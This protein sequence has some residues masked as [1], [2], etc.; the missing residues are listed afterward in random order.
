M[1]A[2]NTGDAYDN[3]NNYIIYIDVK[4]NVI[5]SINIGNAIVTNGSSSLF[6]SIIH[7][8]SS[9]S[10]IDT[11]NIYFG[12]NINYKL[13]SSN[14]K[15]ISGNTRILI[16]SGLQGGARG[17]GTKFTNVKVSTNGDITDTELLS[18]ATFKTAHNQQLFARWSKNKYTV[19]YDANGGTNLSKS[20]DSVYYGDNI[21]LTPTATKEG[22]V[23]AGWSASKNASDKE[24]VIKMGSSNITLYAVWIKEIYAFDYTGDEQTFVVPVSGTY[25]I[26]TW[27]AQGGTGQLDKV[28]LGGYTSGKI[29]L[30]KNTSLYLYVGEAGET[31]SMPYGTKITYNGGGRGCGQSNYEDTRFWGSGGGATDIRLINGDWNNYESLKS[32]IMVAAAG[33]GS[34]NTLAGGAGGGL[35]GYD[36][37]NDGEY[38]YW[39]TKGV[40]GNINTPGYTYLYSSNGWN[41]NEGK[42]FIAGFGYGGTSSFPASGGGSGYYGGGPS[43]HV[44]SAGGGSSFISGHNG[45][46]AISEESTETNIIHTGQSVHYSGYK[47]TNTVMVDGAGYN[48]TTEKG[49][50]TGMPSHD[51]KSTMTGNE[52]NGYAKITLISVD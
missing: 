37:L 28:G 27:G 36:G 18:N 33:G 5:Y 8:F 32:R 47:F 44:Q 52:G 35:F 6:T 24:N 43:T 21:D 2:L 38:Y 7:N 14:L 42:Y 49:E 11:K 25:K 12:E 23:F 10:T 17:I 51:G 13:S 15:E 3:Y 48:W 22:Y 30:D 1:N 29:K 39:G 40:G 34:F 46:D 41:W 26:E 4:P 20:S 31:T 45:C 50:Y 16:Y 9:S 19:T